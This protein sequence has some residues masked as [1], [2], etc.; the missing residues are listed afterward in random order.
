MTNSETIYV[1]IIIP[2]HNAAAT[3]KDTVCSALNQD[4][5]NHASKSS[6]ELGRHLHALDDIIIDIAV[7]C[8]DDGS[9]DDSFKILQDMKRS[10]EEKKYDED[11]SPRITFLISQTTDGKAYGAGAARNR[12]VSLRKINK[13]IMDNNHFLCLLDSDDIMHNHRVAEQVSVMLNLPKNE[14]HQ[15]LLGSNFNRTPA[16]STW[17]YTHWANNLTDERLMLERFREVTI[18]QPT[19]MLTRKRFDLLGGYI[20]AST[21]ISIEESVTT[22]ERMRDVKK[23]SVYKLIHPEHDTKQTLRVAEDLRFF[24]AHLRYPKKV[25][26]QEDEDESCTPSGMS[27]KLKLH[28]TKEPLVT[29]RHRAGQSQSSS[30]PRRLLLQLRAKALEDTILRCEK[31]WMY[32]QERREG[33]FVIWGAGRDG[34]DFFKSLSPEIRAHVRCFVDVDEKK[35]KN[36]YYVSPVSTNKEKCR[37]PI[38]HFSL[39]VSSDTLRKEMTESWIN[40]DTSS[41]HDEISGKISKKRPRSIDSGVEKTIITNV[42][43]KEKHKTGQRLLHNIGRKDVDNLALLDKLKELPV[44][45][46]VAMYRT[47]GVLERNVKNIGRVEGIN[48]WHFS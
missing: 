8:H 30:T 13:G 36:G 43:K 15:T 28:R 46:C 41:K 16:E 14:M 18:L 6:D 37:I 27:G 7:C 29:Y 39:L 3:I 12:A 2:V 24:Y 19:W 4:L 17:H 25:P 5:P 10:M 32:D 11:Q 26:G 38:V 33:G 21:N 31:S 34:K 9:T 23:A 48:L 47:N 1:D 40:G 20:E 22:E 45:V 35:I 44:V 42:T